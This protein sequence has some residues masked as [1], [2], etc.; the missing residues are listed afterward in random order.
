MLNAALKYQEMGFSVIPVAGNKKPAIKSWLPFQK[1]K[2]DSK[3]IIQWWNN[4]PNANIGIVTGANSNLTV[5]D[6]DS[7]EAIAT[8]NALGELPQ[9]P[10]ARTPRGGMHVYFK[11]TKGMRTASNVMTKTDTRDEGGYIIVAPSANGKGKYTWEPGRSI[12]EVRPP[13]MPETVVNVFKNAFNREG[14]R[15]ETVN[16]TVHRSPQVSTNVHNFLTEGNRDE[17][18]FCLANHLVKGGMSPANIENYLYFFAANCKPPFPVNEVQAKISSALQRANN[19]ERN[20]TQDI[21]DWIV[22]TKGNFLTTDAYIGQHLTTR[23]E[24]KKALV[25]LGRFAKEGFIERTGSKAGCYRLV[26]NDVVG[27]RWIGALP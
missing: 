3:Q 14:Y 23:D 12:F 10:A 22:T 19:Q 6:L 9:T 17:A 18:L 16:H 4:N 1:E 5:V 7:P 11:H 13:E 25:I 20:L 15:G 21:K 8:F 26:E 27:L 24:K 2:A